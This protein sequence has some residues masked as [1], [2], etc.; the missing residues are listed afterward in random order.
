MIPDEESA[1][2][3]HPN[4]DVR[5]RSEKKEEDENSSKTD[6]K[7]REIETSKVPAAHQS[8]HSRSRAKSFSAD[9]NSFFAFVRR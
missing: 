2:R 3:Y 1:R 7:N 9:A 4:F 8:E 5:F 6:V